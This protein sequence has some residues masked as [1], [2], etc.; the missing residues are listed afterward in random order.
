[1]KVN[2]RIV[3]CS[4]YLNGIA[5]NVEAFIK[6]GCLEIEGQDLGA[7]VLGGDEEYEYFYSF[8][9]TE[10]KKFAK[11]LIGN[12]L[13]LDSFLVAFAGCFSG[14]HWYFKFIE[15]CEENELHYS[16]FSC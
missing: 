6:D 16:F 7:G 5:R 13:N 2:R 11:I 12:P 3:L 1:M 8:N 4:D 14:S 9:D 10:T 15:F